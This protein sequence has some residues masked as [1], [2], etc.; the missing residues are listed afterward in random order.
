V[1]NFFDACEGRPEEEWPDLW[2][3]AQRKWLMSRGWG[4]YSA[5]AHGHHF[6]RHFANGYIIVSGMTPRGHMHAVVYKDGEL[7]HDPH[8][9][10][11]GL[12]E[13]FDVDILYPLNPCAL[14]SQPRGPAMSDLEKFKSLLDSVGAN[15]H[16]EPLSFEYKDVCN[17]LSALG[18][19]V[20]AF[21][22]IKM[23][24]LHSKHIGY[25]GFITEIY[26]DAAGKFL[27]FGS[28]E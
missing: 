18:K 11:T 14:A 23:T 21:Q 3:A 2:F 4:V 22:T 6:K 24:N 19:K 8:P 15:Y 10:H 28:W 20:N 25:S 7:F 13:I 1:P 16:F 12:T 9:D 5:G 17:M 27:A 26:F